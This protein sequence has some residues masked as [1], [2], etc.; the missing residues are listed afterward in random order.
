MNIYIIPILFS[1][2]LIAC[3]MTPQKVDSSQRDAKQYSVNKEEEAEHDTCSHSFITI[4]LFNDISFKGELLSNLKNIEDTIYI[5]SRHLLKKFETLEHSESYIRFGYHNYEVVVS[6][7]DFDESIHMLNLVDTIRKNDGSVDYL[8]VNNLING[9]KAYGIDGNKP[10]TELKAFIVK[11][12]NQTVNIPDTLFGDLFNVNLHA[13]EVFYDSD[14]NLIYIYLD[15]SDAA[16]GYSAKFVF[17]GTEYITRI[18][19]EHC[20]FNFIDG[21]KYDCI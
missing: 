7:K 4:S 6:I 10:N 18:I 11:E 3:N 14:R 17:E 19:A 20:G 1:S 15:G 12:N 9:R 13:S 2:L 21:I 16:G 5:Y 8:K